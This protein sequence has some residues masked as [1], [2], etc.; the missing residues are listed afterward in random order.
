M[1]D[2]QGRSNKYSFVVVPVLYEYD[3]GVPPRMM[4]VYADHH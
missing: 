3:R 1:D 4:Y 2:L